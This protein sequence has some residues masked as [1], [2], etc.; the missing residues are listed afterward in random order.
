MPRLRAL[1]PAFPIECQ[2]ALDATPVL[3]A[4]IITP[5]RADEQDWLKAWE[6]DAA[7]MKRQPRF[8]SAQLHCAIGD[9]PNRSERC[10]CGSRSLP[11]G[12]H[13][14]SRIQ[15]NPLLICLVRSGFPH[16]FQKVAVP[17]ICVA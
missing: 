11:S 5:D 16:L 14:Q 4:N 15:S 6:N 13:H 9:S 12:R 1:E 17:D 2:L 7:F 8:I 3:L 10:E